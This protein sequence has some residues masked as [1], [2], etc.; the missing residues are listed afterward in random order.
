MTQSTDE[1]RKEIWARRKKTL[2][3]RKK[4]PTTKRMPRPQRGPREL[5]PT[6]GGKFPGLGTLNGK[7]SGETIFVLGNS[8]SLKDMDMSLLEPFITIGVNRI[9]RLMKPTYLYI[10]NKS[11]IDSDHE[12]ILA[13]VE[14]L[15]VILYPG[16]FNSK[17]V[18]WLGRDFPHIKGPHLP[19][20]G[21]PTKR[22]GPMPMGRGGGNSGYQAAQIAYRMGAKRIV[23][24][25][26][27]LISRSKRQS[28]FYG[29]G[30]TLYKC[31]L[32]AVRLKVE[33]FAAM[34]R[35]YQAQGVEL[36]SCSPWKS[37]LRTAV[38]Y[39]PLSSIK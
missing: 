26:Q 3:R 36:T 25:G 31:R 28:H 35:L 23:L 11:V 8:T 13:A 4:I 12:S 29:D 18:Q 19:H 10:V 34:K 16:A 6:R 20:H 38:G 39:T 5:R 1:R 17:T 22:S 2:A 21:D 15:T 37:A 32:G 7:H 27:D 30:G 24:A 33:D 14:K 9:L